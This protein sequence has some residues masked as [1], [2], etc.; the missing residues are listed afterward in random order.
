MTAAQAREIKRLAS[1]LATARVRQ[2]AAKL[3]RVGQNGNT[4]SVTSTAKRVA[5]AQDKLDTYLH[6]ITE[7]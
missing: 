6:S 7:Y 2:Y 1:L 3:G 5:T 4:E